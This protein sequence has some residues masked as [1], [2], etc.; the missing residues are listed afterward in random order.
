MGFGIP[1]DVWFRAELR[2]MLQDLLLDH[3]RTGDLYRPG[4]IASVLEQHWSG[5]VNW[6]YPIWT[7]LALEFFWRKW[8][9]SWDGAHLR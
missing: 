5:A 4:A 8:Q 1:I 7:M 9:P 6:Y 3:P 2:P